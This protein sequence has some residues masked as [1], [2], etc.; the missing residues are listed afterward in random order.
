MTSGRNSGL[1]GTNTWLA[2]GQIGHY[3]RIVYY[4]GRPRLMR[5]DDPN[6]DQTYYLSSVRE[7]KL[8]RVS[9]P[10]NTPHI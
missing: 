1:P 2:T 5:S 6:K 10:I 8:K 4:H 3:A 7:N 9:R